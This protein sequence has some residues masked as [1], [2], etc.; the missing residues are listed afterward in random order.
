[1]KPTKFC[2]LIL[3]ALTGL[4]LSGCFQVERVVKLKA[5]GSGTIE[6]TV[7]MGSAM[8]AQMKAMQAGFGNA[9]E[10]AVEGDA[11][12]DKPKDKP[13]RNRSSCS[14]KPSSRKKRRDGRRRDVRVREESHGQGPR[15]LRATFA[16]TDINKLRFDMAPPDMGPKAAQTCRQGPGAVD[17][18]VCQGQTRN[19]EVA[20]PTPKKDAKEA[21]ADPAQEAM[22]EA[23]LPMMQQMFKD[24]RLA[25]SIEVQ[26]K[27]VSTNAQFKDASRVTIADIDFNKILADPAKFK[28]MAK[29]TDPNSAEGKAFLKTVPGSRSRP[30]AR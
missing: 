14:M 26:G 17:V 8:I 21:A 1:M 11:A 4:C 30:T 9:L 27:I 22:Q 24:M 3:A 13:A 23:M 5:D 18:Q 7:T 2:S 29:I 6:E 12:K 25:A 15:G 19:L 10:G 28:A 20:I 16:F